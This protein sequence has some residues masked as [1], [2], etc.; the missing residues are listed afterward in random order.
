MNSVSSHHQA[1]L[2]IVFGSEI[3]RF[4]LSENTYG[5][6]VGNVCSVFQ[7]L[8]SAIN[9]CYIDE[10]GDQVR[11]TSDGELNFALQHNQNKLKLILSTKAAQSTQP[12]LPLPVAEEPRWRRYQ[13]RERPPSKDK[14][15]K[16]SKF[17]A[18]VAS[19]FFVIDGKV[20]RSQPK[21]VLKPGT[22]FSKVFVIRNESSNPWPADTKVT[23]IKGDTEDMQVP[24]S[25]AIPKSI[26]PN[27]EFNIVV[28]GIA[29]Q[30][31]G[32]HCAVYRMA[33]ASGEFFGRKLRCCTKVIDEEKPRREAPAEEEL[34]TQLKMMGF[35]NE[36]LNKRLIC[37]KKGNFERVLDTLTAIESKRERKNSNRD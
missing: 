35:S 23:L 21:L 18:Y 6:L 33:D 15:A 13:R 22:K 17:D 19:E 25:I 11:I 14:P 31:P 3:R 5:C 32:K 7:T 16:W 10:E 28:C 12:E 2:K 20:E 30:Q 8:P 26:L 27:E 1:D 34:L 37:Q 36:P 4:S 29:P 24:S 9:L